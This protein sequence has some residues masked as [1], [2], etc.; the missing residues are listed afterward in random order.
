MKIYLSG[1]ISND[2]NYIEKFN[3][4]EKTLKGKGEV[5]NP[6]THQPFLGRKT[7]FCYMVTSIY[8]LLGCN[9]IYMIPG[10]E[11]SRGA[12]I[13]RF[14]AKIAGIDVVIV[15]RRPNPRDFLDYKNLRITDCLNAWYV[16]YQT[17]QGD[18][19]MNIF[20]KYKR[21]NPLWIWRVIR[22]IT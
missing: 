13:E 21:E 11:E 22:R 18:I 9:A 6:V 12:K 4:Y 7:W 16:C 5:I 17:A 2:P 10:W 19:A 1:A 14:V 20:Y 3:A 15:N 8:R